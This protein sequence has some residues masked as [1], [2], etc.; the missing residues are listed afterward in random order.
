MDP[1]DFR[2]LVSGR[3]R[4]VRAWL[5]RLGLRALEIPYAL[6]MRVR[7]WRYDT[8]RSEI[9][10]VSVPVV[11][12]G[13][14]TMGGTGKTPMVAW[15][16]RWFRQRG[17]RV[18]VISRGYGAEE[19]SRNDEAMEL[20]HQ[21]PDVPHVQNPDR[22]AAAE[23]A[24]EEFE[25]QVI[26]LDDAFQHRR[27]ARDL[28]LVLLD[29]LE[30][31]GFGHVFPRGM[32]REPMAGLKRADLVVLS[33][34]DTA[35]PEARQRVRHAVLRRAPRAAWAEVVHA[36][37]GLLGAAGNE[38]GLETLVGQPVAAF[39]GIGNPAGFRRTLDAAGYEVVAFREFSDHHRYTREEIGWLSDWVS[40]ADATAVL[41]THK[42]LVKLQVEQLAGRPLWAVV[43]GIEFLLGR[44]ALEERLS[45]LLP[46][47]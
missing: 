32:M 16:A 45:R 30:P 38:E 13:N 25:C 37:R 46:D 5:A 21:L 8:G 31:F 23:M 9:R 20:E 43:V 40:G 3:R 18:T 7:N 36:P 17:V 12:V 24:I 28:D 42:D 11:S 19:G 34:A 4:G 27:I 29:A 26:V 33:R 35:E 22:V 39:C 47:S 6:A 14:L 41:C 15:I 1:S 2:D 10:R 44:E